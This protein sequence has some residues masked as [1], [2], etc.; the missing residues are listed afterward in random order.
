MGVTIKHHLKVGHPVL[1]H[2]HRSTWCEKKARLF[3]LV[4]LFKMTWT[5][6]KKICVCVWRCREDFC[7]VFWFFLFY[8]A[9]AKEH[10]KWCAKSVMCT[11]VSQQRRSAS[12]SLTRSKISFHEVHD[13]TRHT[14]SG[15]GNFGPGGPLSCRVS[16]NP[17]QT[18]QN[19]LMNVF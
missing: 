13:M 15:L 1:T 18:H 3:A 12:W 9:C 19:Q 11:S 6:H 5:V 16:S 2:G 4:I 8:F 7:Q 10:P 17:N 14:T